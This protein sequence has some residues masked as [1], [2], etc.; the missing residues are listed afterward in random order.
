MGCGETKMISSRVV[1]IA[2][3]RFEFDTNLGGTK[4]PNKHKVKAFP[5]PIIHFQNLMS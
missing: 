4:H 3:M 5:N 2:C 1:D